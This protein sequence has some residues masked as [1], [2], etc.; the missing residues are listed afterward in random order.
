MSLPL[1][2]PTSMLVGF[3]VLGPFY[4]PGLERQELAFGQ[5]DIVLNLSRHGKQEVVGSA[6]RG[7]RE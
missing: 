6:V 7:D 3:K 2:I 1:E 5:H 4:Q